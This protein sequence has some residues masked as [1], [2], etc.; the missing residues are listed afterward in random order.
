ME[1]VTTHATSA[2]AVSRKDVGFAQSQ[3]WMIAQ[4][5]LT[6]AYSIL[7]RLATDPEFAHEEAH[8]LLIHFFL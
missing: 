1:K 6:R 8:R 4:I 5:D 2:D 7:R 3:G